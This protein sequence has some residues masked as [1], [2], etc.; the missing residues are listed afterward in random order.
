M[1][2]ARS[3]YLQQLIDSQANGLVKT[4]TG[5]RR[6]GKSVLLMQLF[7]KWLIGQNVPKDHIIDIS[8]DELSKE[9]LKDPK[10][11]LSLV[12]SRVTDNGNYYILLDEVQQMEN[13]VSVLLS[14]MHLP[15]CDI[16]VTGSNSRFLSTD[17]V[18]EFRGRSQEI[19]LQPLSFSEFI[20]G[21][22]GGRDAAWREYYE[23]GGLPQILSLKTRQQ[24]IEYL[25]N[26]VESVYLADLV[27]RNKIKNDEGLKTFIRILSSSIGAPTNPSRIAKTFESVEKKHITSETLAKYIKYLEEAFM[28]S[29]A[30]RYDVKG[31]KYIGTETKYYFSDMGLRNSILDFRQVEENHLMENILY[32][33]L[34]SRG[35]I[36]D[37]GMVE[38]MGRDKDGKPTRKR[39]EIDFVANQGSKRFY[40]QSAF[41]ID[42]EEKEEQEQKSLL[43][44]SDSFKKIILVK[45][46]I[47]PYYDYNGI[48][49]MG[50][51]DFLLQTK[52]LEEL[53]P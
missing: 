37:V 6:C 27:E 39:L 12:K 14:L 46:D 2:L 42:N 1:I 35:Y 16:Y 34:R 52:P 40:I 32:N 26:L 11:F 30:L 44:I 18:T 49:R 15:N 53:N 23:F 47:A 48:L 21:Y 31:R 5:I 13:F 10:A 9:D 28:I 22:D 50:L 25:S 33:E 41:R 4:I 7:Y 3:R 38:T 43:N 17:I 24:K 20:E 45:D 51:F 19:H 29:E 8:F 36:V